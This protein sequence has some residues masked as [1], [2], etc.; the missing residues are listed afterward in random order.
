MRKL[1]TTVIVAALLASAAAAPAFAGYRYKQHGFGH[2]Y[3]NYG[4]H[5]Y[6][7][8]P[9]Y[10]SGYRHGARLGDG[11]ATAFVGRLSRVEKERAMKK[12]VAAIAAAALLVTGAPLKTERQNSAE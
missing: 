7:Y 4:G 3:S 12:L 6:K 2:D 11:L 5:Y 8:R 1:I 10:R 9:Y